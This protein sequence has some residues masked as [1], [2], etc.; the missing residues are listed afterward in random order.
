LNRLCQVLLH[1]SRHPRGLTADE[2][3]SAV[4][5]S[6]STFFRD[7]QALQHAGVPIELRDGRYLFLNAPAVPPLSLTAEQLA[8]LHLARLQLVPL[9]GSLLL[10]ELDRFLGSLHI[11]GGRRSTQTSFRFMEPRRPPPAPKVVRAIEKALSAKRLLWIEYRA[12]TRGGAVTRV[13]IEPLVVSVADADP[14]VSALCV[15][16][17]AERTY[18]LNRIQSV[19]VT[20]Q[21]ATRRRKQATSPF[22]QAVKA[23]SGA[24]RVIKVRLDA[25]VAWRARE[26]ALPRQTE[27]ST[28]DGSVVV[29]AEVAGLVEVRSWILAWGAAAEVLEPDEL[30]NAVR[31]ELAQALRKYDG[32]G[33]AKVSSEKSRGAMASVSNRLRPEPGKQTG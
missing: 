17:N 22:A 1:L 26:Y 19:E 27:H 9:G 12:A 3:R 20:T 10:Q 32:P 2:I 29:C 25:E 18:K 4:G 23:W 16:R 31:A 30:R 21:R 6:R 8:S 28:P 14:Y 11:S 5:A 13:H 7:L 33:P 15:A 24:P